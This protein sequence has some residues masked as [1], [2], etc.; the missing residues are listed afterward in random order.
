M[1]KKKKCEN[2][3]KLRIPYT[4]WTGSCPEFLAFLELNKFLDNIAPS[5][6]YFTEKSRWAPVTVACEEA[7]CEKSRASGTQKEMC[8]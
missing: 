4:D 7:H 5:N 8:K 1:V 2:R 6:S 3:C